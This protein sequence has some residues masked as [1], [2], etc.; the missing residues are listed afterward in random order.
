M[1]RIAFIGLGNMGLPMAR[2]LLKAGYTVAGF[3]LVQA[4]VTQL[5]SEGARAASSAKDA[6]QDADVVVSMLPAGRQVEDL[7]LGEDGLLTELRPGCLVIECSTIA[8]TTAR[9]VHRAAA[10]R[11]LEMLDA[12][13]S[14][15]TA[16][17]AAGSL[18][19]MVG[20]AAVTL[21][22]ARPILS[23][24]GRNIFHAGF[25]SAGQLAKL[26]NNLLL[27]VQMAGTAE[28]MALGARC[29]LDAGVLSEIMRQSSGANWVL[30]RYNPWP[31]VQPGSPA[32]HDYQPGFIAGLMTKD[33][34]LIQETA[35]QAGASTPMSSLALSLYRMLVQ[36]GLGGKDFS[37]I[38]KLFIDRS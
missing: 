2:N 27:A 26:C 25:P 12:P 7:Y 35:L 13:V 10:A 36:Q 16:G 9:H 24:M 32:S 19:F 11:G 30:E 34:G 1:A 31:G 14:G 38:Q 21:E 4:V 37:V 18:T 3:D 28:A 17:A 8:P 5:A 15:G 29:G 22:K 20:G 23:A 6:V 33:L